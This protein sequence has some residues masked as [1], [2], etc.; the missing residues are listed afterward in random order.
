MFHDGRL[1]MEDKPFVRLTSIDIYVSGAISWKFSIA[2]IAS[3][4]T[5]EALAIG[6]TLEIIKKEIDS[7]QN[8]AIFSDPESV[9]KGNGNT[10]S[11]SNTSHITQILKDRTDWNCERKNPNL[12]DP[13]A[14]WS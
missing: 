10:S 6:E 5:A 11:M 14:M 3:T 7:E 8:F 1:K 13:G 4:F 2:K 12:L 9:L